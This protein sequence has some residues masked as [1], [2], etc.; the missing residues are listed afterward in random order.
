M[1][2]IFISA[3]TF[4][5]SLWVDS[6]PDPARQWLCTPAVAA[7]VAIIFNADLF[8]QFD[9]WT[10]AAI[11]SGNSSFAL[12]IVETVPLVVILLP[13]VY[14]FDKQTQNINARPSSAEQRVEISTF[15]VRIRTDLIRFLLFRFSVRFEKKEPHLSVDSP[16]GAASVALI[17]FAC[18]LYAAPTV[19]QNGKVTYQSAGWPA[20]PFVGCYELE[21]GRWW[22]WG[23]GGDSSFVTPPKRVQFLAEPGIEG[24]EQDGFLLRG[25]AEPSK[26][27]GDEGDLRIG[28]WT[29]RSKSC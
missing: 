12:R 17:L 9:L 20:A 4:V 15:C 28:R 11:R 14:P 7:I 27:V 25:I 1:G 13:I 18:S 10:K 26:P 23:Y 29:L 8:Y 2:L 3:E 16:I 22:P 24:F 21:L 19:A 6:L 5:A